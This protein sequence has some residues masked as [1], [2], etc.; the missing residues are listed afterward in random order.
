VISYPPS[1][2]QPH[3]WRSSPGPNG[4]L[5]T[6]R[7]NLSSGGMLLNRSLYTTVIGPACGFLAAFFFAHSTAGS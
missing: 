7:S 6:T 3:T 1:S 5:N 2:P 4:W